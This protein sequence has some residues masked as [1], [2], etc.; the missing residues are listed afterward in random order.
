MCDHSEHH[1][2]MSLTDRAAPV[3]QMVEDATPSYGLSK[4]SLIHGSM[5]S[6][7]WADAGRQM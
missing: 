3:V 6:Q 5:L 7:A 1:R 2:R 4:C